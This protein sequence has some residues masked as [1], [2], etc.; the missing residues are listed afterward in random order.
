MIQLWTNYSQKAQYLQLYVMH[1][2]TKI[3]E[4]FV[5]LLAFAIKNFSFVP[6]NMC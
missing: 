6:Y 5:N 2:K 3:F 1:V 4:W